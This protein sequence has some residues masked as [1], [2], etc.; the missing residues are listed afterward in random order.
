VPLVPLIRETSD[1]GAPVVASHASGPEAR[2]FLAIAS[3]VAQK[4]AAPS[5]KA[6]RIVME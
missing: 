3:E 4:I 5:R 1:S 6:P 2:A